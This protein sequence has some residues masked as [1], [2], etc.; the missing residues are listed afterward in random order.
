[1][2]FWGKKIGRA[3]PPLNYLLYGSEF[4]LRTNRFLASQE[5]SR[6]L[7]NP[8]V[9]NRMHK[10]P[11]PVLFQSLLHPVH[12]PTSHF[13]KIHLNTI[14]SSTHGFT[15]WSVSLRF[16]HNKPVYAS[17]HPIRTT[18]PAHLFFLDF[19][20]RTILDEGYRSLSFSL[21]SFIPSPVTSSLLDPNIILNNLFSNTLSLRSSLNVSDQV[22]NPYKTAGKIRVLYTLI[23][24]FLDSELK[25]KRFFAERYQP[26]P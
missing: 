17:P 13:L 26:F 4:F 19:I 6:V 18:R 1:M 8:K 10:C 3:T 20:T 25:D 2:Y 23:F 14:L 15:K 16:P 24:K 11:A 12:T 22:S 5:I 9:H 7:W 21:R